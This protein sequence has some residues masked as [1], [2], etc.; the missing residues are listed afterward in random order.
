M[1]VLFEVK[2]ID[3]GNGGAGVPGSF[4]KLKR[5]E[6][7]AMKRN[8]PQVSSACC[9]NSSTKKHTCC[10]DPSKSENLRAHRQHQCFCFCIEG[11]S[12]DRE[13]SMKEA[14][15]GSFYQPVT[16]KIN[17]IVDEPSISQSNI[18]CLRGFPDESCGFGGRDGRNSRVKPCKSVED[19]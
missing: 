7:L 12:S 16:P 18:E 4:L 11:H 8:W 3:L 1:S 13:C 9:T 10:L 5:L 14:V 15:C 6:M 19:E 17:F 2:E